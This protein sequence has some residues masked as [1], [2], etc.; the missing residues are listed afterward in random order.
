MK[1]IALCLSGQARTWK[2]CYQNWFDNLSHIPCQIDIFAHFWDYNTMPMQVWSKNT[3]NNSMKFEDVKLSDFE[4]NEIVEILKPKNIIFEQKLNIPTNFYKVKNKVSW[5]TV[6]QF[7]SLLKSSIIKKKYELDNNF[8]YDVV[9]RMRSD[10]HFTSK[11]EIDDPVVENMV[12]VT[13][14]SWDSTYNSFRISDIFFMA[15]SPTYD[16]AAAFYDFFPHID[17]KYVTNDNNKLHYPPELAFYYYLKSVG[18][19]IQG[20]G[21]DIKVMRTPEYVAIKGHLDG[22]EII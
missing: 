10:L 9:I 1:K 16:Q 13:H 19:N 17:A 18:I 22:Y 14:T 4:K 15:D 20:T 21:L 2:K 8:Q 6:D 12:Y 11:I 7:N 3:T 5:W